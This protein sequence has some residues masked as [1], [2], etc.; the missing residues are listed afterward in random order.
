[1]KEGTLILYGSGF[2]KEVSARDYER[3]LAHFRGRTVY[4]GVSRGNPPP[5]SLGKWLQ[6]NVCKTAIASY[7]GAILVNEDYAKKKC[8][9]IEFY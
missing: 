9:E 7:V 6:E 8:D 5:D 1:M 4:C 3:M 2:S